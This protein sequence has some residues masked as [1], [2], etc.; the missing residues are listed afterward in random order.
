[1]NIRKYTKL[2]PWESVLGDL[3]GPGFKGR[4][5][6]GSE[7][8]WRDHQE[9]QVSKMEGFLNLIAGYFGGGFWVP[10]ILGDWITNGIFLWSHIGFMGLVTWWPDMGAKLVTESDMWRPQTWSPQNIFC[11]WEHTSKHGRTYVYNCSWWCEK[12]TKNKYIAISKSKL[13]RL[14]NLV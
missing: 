3:Q 12:K 5:Y 10:E 9:F 4:M 11:M 6:R 14:W 7:V 13:G 1:M 8:M 2:V